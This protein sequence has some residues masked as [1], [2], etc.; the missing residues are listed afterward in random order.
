MV[1][2]NF[3]RI[4]IFISL[5]FFI[6][7]LSSADNHSTQEE[8][9]SNKRRVIRT[10]TIIAREFDRHAKKTGGAGFGYGIKS[11]VRSLIY[12]DEY[13]ER[14]Q[15]QVLRLP[16]YMLFTTGLKED[17]PELSR[18]FISFCNMMP[19]TFDTYTSCS[20]KIKK[21]LKAAFPEENQAFYNDTLKDIKKKSGAMW[22]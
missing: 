6:S 22:L 9:V 10:L 11:S 7:N 5:F 20:T 14:F 8:T 17:D 18:K 13:R 12:S 2:K 19:T 15:F 3:A 1:G 21:I 16:Y 4:L